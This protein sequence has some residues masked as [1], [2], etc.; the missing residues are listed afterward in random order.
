MHLETMRSC[1]H[2]KLLTAGLLLGLAL[3][4]AAIPI[5]RPQLLSPG[6]AQREA[7]VGTA[8]PTFSW[9]DVEGA[10]GYTLVVYEAS[11]PDQPGRAPR[12]EPVL[13]TN[14]PARA[15]SWTP[16]L[17]ECLQAPGRYGWSVGALGED[18]Q[19]IWSG[20]G[21]F[22]VVR[23]AA[24]ERD[25]PSPPA[26]PGRPATLGGTAAPL[27]QPQASSAVPVASRAQSPQR[28]LGAQAFT[29]SCTGSVFSDV[30]AAHP[31]C[32]WIETIAAD[33]IVGQCAAGRFCPEHPVTRGQ[34][35]MFMERAMRGTNAWRPE[36]GDGSAP[37]LPPAVPTLTT[38]PLFTDLGHFTSATIGAD[39]L[40]LISFHGAA[41]LFD[42]N[43]AHCSNVLC[44]EM[45]AATL[46][47]VGNVGSYTSI[48]IGRDGL[49]LISYHNAEL[50]TLKVA[51]CT[52]VNCSSATVN[53]LDTGGVGLFTSITIGADGLGLISYY[54]GTNFDLKVAHCADV[55]C[56]SA[57]QITPLDTANDVGYY[58]SITIGADGL[59]LISYFNNTSND[60]KVAHC[61][62]TN[63][64]GATITPLATATDTGL[65]TSITIGADGLGLISYFEE[66]DLSP[67]D[68]DKNLWVAHCSNVLCSSA[69]HTRL[70]QGGHGEH[71]SITIGADG[72][73]LISY[74]SVAPAGDLKV[75]HCANVNCT[76]ATL[77]P[78]DT[79]DNVG[80]YT[81]VT[82]G[83]DGLGLIS[84]YDVT[85]GHLKVAHCPNEHCA[86][87]FRRR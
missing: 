25:R 4:A 9:T 64:T 59:G 32:A 44:T 74:Y 42:F 11:D 41:P 49:G 38:L 6:G 21:V 77:T 8:C 47:N 24:P 57:D 30:S 39:G 17:E 28:S 12:P 68:P 72:L 82:L 50:G 22:R 26:H 15:A 35:A 53:T 60:L 27:G 14:L 71:T 87:Y 63:C 36:A 85:N 54:D 34:M 45:T 65:Y 29:P 13:K 70:E 18:D 55:L 2:P 52:N 1:F 23:S 43:V 78:V 46:D 66:D 58:T 31:Y 48:T 19:L 73:G 67:F 69:T 83:A 10:R 86:P 84:Y 16:S 20:P 3:P 81:A 75:A 61:F 33:E 40:G 5:A 51:H 76:A 79:T 56:S 37:N 80:Q 7:R 62:D